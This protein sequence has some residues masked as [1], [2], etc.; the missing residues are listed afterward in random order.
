MFNVPFVSPEDALKLVRSGDRLYIGSNCAQPETLCR[1]LC[2][3]A[4]RL[5]GVEIVHLI[6]FGDAPYLLPQYAES[7]RHV[8]FFVGPNSRAAVSEGRADY[9]PIFLSEIPRLFATGQMA[10]DV[11]LVMVSPPDSHGYCS[12]GVSVDL[13]LSACRL[14]RHVIAEVNPNMPKTRGDSVLHVSEIDAF[15]AVDT[16]IIEHT[17]PQ[18]DHISEAIG[19]HVAELIDDGATIQ[20]G[21]GR[22]PSA[23]LQELRDKN[24]LGVHTE[25]F[26]EPMVQ[27]MRAG[28]ITGRRK[29]LHPEVVVASFCLGNRDVYDYLND[30]PQFYF[31]PTEYVNDIDVIAQN[32]RLV[33]INGAIEVDITG[34]VVAD[35]IGTHLYSGIGGQV[36]F[37][38]GAARSKGGKPVITL[39]S[40]AGEKSRVVAT[41]SPGA[42][43]VTSRGDVHYIVTEYGVA[44]LHGKT[45]RDRALAIIK[46]AHPS[47]RDELLADAKRLGYIPSDQPSIKP[48]YPHEWVTRWTT[49]EGE[50][51]VIRPIQ[52]TDHHL[53]ERHF[54]SLSKQA[55]NYRF[56]RAKRILEH[57][58]V[59]DFV[60]IDYEDHMAFVAVLADGETEMILATARYMVNNTDNSAEIALAI[61]DDWQRKGLGKRLLFNLTA[62]ARKA[63]L[64]SLLAYVDPANVGMVR[65]IESSGEPWTR[66]TT[67]DE[68]IF[69]LNLRPPKPSSESTG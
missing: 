59:M 36:D 51:L 42:G 49:D 62:H 20:T 41:I 66:K 30:N 61:L 9:M 1:A 64:S 50:Q 57:R 63:K 52:P 16:P 32:D 47:V 19:R 27:L 45:I 6:V 40:M 21:L 13:G 7:F 11:A 60:N 12:L 25:M 38:R 53:L 10:I 24:D 17:V 5:S 8:A 46:I 39:P 4:N 54:Y 28:N 29:T 14:A 37:V 26:S 58:A 65:L 34:Q 15:V 33:A 22:I 31:A 68:L 56:R 23:I 2:D 55:V 3:Q 44:Y 69:E 67:L 43:V 18:A 35:S 48:E